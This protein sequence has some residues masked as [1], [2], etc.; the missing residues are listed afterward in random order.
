MFRLIILP[1]ARTLSQTQTSSY[2]SQIIT[3]HLCQ[4]S[5]S[6]LQ[7]SR[8]I[9]DRCKW[10][11]ATLPLMM[12]RSALSSQ[13][14][15]TTSPASQSQAR[16]SLLSA[17]SG[18]NRQLHKVQTPSGMTLTSFQ[19]L[20]CQTLL[21]RVSVPACMTKSIISSSSSGMSTH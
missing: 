16:N 9:Y 11:V 17:Q 19:C 5:T 6:Q 8:E 10:S 20:S 4:R 15:L 3:T 18:T 21:S 12:I 2:L 1:L 14:I 13:V 7:T